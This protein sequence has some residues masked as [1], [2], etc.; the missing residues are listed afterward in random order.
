MRAVDL[1]QSIHEF[2]RT[3]VLHGNASIYSAGVKGIIIGLEAFSDIMNDSESRRYMQMEDN[4]RFKFMGIP[5]YRTHDI[6][7]DKV[8]LY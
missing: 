8:E 7:L 6:D 4:F 1:A 5:M 3:Q 2:R